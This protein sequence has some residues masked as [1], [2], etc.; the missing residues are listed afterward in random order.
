VYVV[1]VEGTHAGVTLRPIFLG[2][3]DRFSSDRWTRPLLPLG[4]TAVTPGALLFS[5]AGEFVGSVVLEDGAPAIAGASDLLEVVERLA[6]GPS[7]R[8]ATLGIGVQP[9]TPDLAA[10][11]GVERGVV[12]AEVDEKGPASGILRPGDVLTAL[13]GN[14]VDD[15]ERL[16]LEI[17]SRQANETLAL[18]VVRSGE[19]SAVTIVLA[20]TEDDAAAPD[21]A[22]AFERIRGVGTRVVAAGPAG[23][24][25]ATGLQAGDIIVNA[26]QLDDPTPFQLRRLLAAA[27]PDADVALTIRRQGRQRVVTVRPPSR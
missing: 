15:P 23:G 24:Y 8:P 10:A 18:A 4:G 13:D 17:A 11:L 14:A 7:S 27:P 26:G 12:V 3:G 21:V 1:A 16:L 5:L 22:V 20:M 6:S 19:S 2:R 9:L 25:P